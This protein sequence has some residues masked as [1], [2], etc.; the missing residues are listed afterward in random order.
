MNNLEFRQ[1]TKIDDKNLNMMTNW[2]YNWWV[3][4][5]GIP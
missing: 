2:M 1:I 5:K 4:K 3:K